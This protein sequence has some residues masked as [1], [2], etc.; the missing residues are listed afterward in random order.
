MFCKYN[1]AFAKYTCTFLHDSYAYIFEQNIFRNIKV[2]YSKNDCIL[3]L[4]L[5]KKG[6]ENR[7]LIC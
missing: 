7:H 2:K 1:D 5:Q 4:N 3:T 6:D